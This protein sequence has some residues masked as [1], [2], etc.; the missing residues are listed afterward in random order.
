MLN[1]CSNAINKFIF[2]KTFESKKL[3]QLKFNILYFFQKIQYPGGIK[4]LVF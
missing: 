2:K 3:A 1:V 4:A